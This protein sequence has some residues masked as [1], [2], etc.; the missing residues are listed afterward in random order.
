MRTVWLCQPL[1]SKV[2]RRQGAIERWEIQGGDFAVHQ[3][4]QKTTHFFRRELVNFAI[5]RKILYYHFEQNFLQSNCCEWSNIEQNLY[6]ICNNISYASFSVHPSGTGWG[7]SCARWQPSNK[8]SSALIWSSI[9]LQPAAGLA[10]GMGCQLTKRSNISFDS[11]PWARL[12]SSTSINIG[13]Y[14]SKPSTCGWGIEP[15]K[16]RFENGC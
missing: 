10:Y 2:H 6:R 9:F 12:S 5:L 4:G 1:E 14:W 8:S 16:Q 15:G 7:G 3:G 11:Y 13:L